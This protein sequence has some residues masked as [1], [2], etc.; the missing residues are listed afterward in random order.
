[1]RQ[2]EADICRDKETAKKE[3]IGTDKETVNET[4]RGRYR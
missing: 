3:D 1:M 2:K 4:E